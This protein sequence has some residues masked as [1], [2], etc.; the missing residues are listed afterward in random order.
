MKAYS[1]DLRERIAAACAQPGRT[2]AQIAT[3]YQVSI[4][5]LDKLLHRQ[6]TSGSLLAKPASGGAPPLL[7]ADHQ[8]QLVAWVSQQSDL[9]LREL[10]QR[11]VEAGGPPASLSLLSIVLA[12]HDLRR[13]KRVYTPPSATP[14]GGRRCGR[15]FWK[16]CPVTT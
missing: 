15:L 13:K 5:F 3:Q 4:S 10:Q 8:A 11:L 16:L 6:R 7:T 12:R 1:Q 2:I 9:T 14:T